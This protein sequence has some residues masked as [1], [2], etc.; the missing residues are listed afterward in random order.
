MATSLMDR[1]RFLA[2]FFLKPTLV[3]AVAPSSRFLVDELIKDMGVSEATCLAELGPGTGV[4]THVIM[5]EKS[6]DCAFLAVEKDLQWVKLLNRRYPELDVVHGDAAELDR[7]AAERG[8]PPFDAVICG[9][10][11]TVFSE[12]LQRAILDSIKCCLRPGGSFS[13]FAYVHGKE[14]PTGKRFFGLLEESFDRVEVS[15]VIWRNTPPAVVY[16]AWLASG[17]S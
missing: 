10:P 6:E 4:A 11:F 5:Q 3:G 13:T 15:E 2:R 9:L 17:D 16:R 7:F 12:P 14:L 1:L 8:L